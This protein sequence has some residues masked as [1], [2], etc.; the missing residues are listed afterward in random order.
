MWARCGQNGEAAAVPSS[1]SI[2]LEA[3]PD[4]SLEGV[5][6]IQ[7]IEG[8]VP[9]ADKKSLVQQWADQGLGCRG[10]KSQFLSRRCGVRAVASFIASLQRSR[11]YS[12]GEFV[13]GNFRRQ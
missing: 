2:R 12:T 7:A 3:L 4:L 13:L 11:W 10:R 6:R 9:R 8:D 5:A 1:R